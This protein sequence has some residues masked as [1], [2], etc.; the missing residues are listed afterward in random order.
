[1]VH[2]HKIGTSPAEACKTRVSEDFS[3]SSSTHGYAGRQNIDRMEH[4]EPSTLNSGMAECLLQRR[5]IM[6]KEISLAIMATILLLQLIAAGTSGIVSTIASEL[7]VQLSSQS[8]VVAY[9]VA[10]T[11]LARGE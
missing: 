3:P 9:P 6:K 10:N 8:H 7:V 11:E 1:V 4:R 2:E 5:Q